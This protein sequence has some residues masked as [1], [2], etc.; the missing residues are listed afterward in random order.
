MENKKYVKH[1]WSMDTCRPKKVY[2]LT[3]A[4]KAML[5]YTVNSLNLICNVIGK[6]NEQTE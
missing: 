4:G 6:S 5:D 1:K 2:E 3:V